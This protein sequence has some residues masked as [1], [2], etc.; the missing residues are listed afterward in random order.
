MAIKKIKATKELTVPESGSVPAF[1]QDQV[2]ADA[3]KGV[4]TNAEDN[5]VPLIYV[6][7]AQSP[8]CNRRSPDFVEGAEAGAFWLRSS[9]LPAVSGDDG[10][11]FQPCFFSKDW[12][13]WRP[14]RGGFVTR[15][16]DR[17]ADAEL[18][19]TPTPEDPDRQSWVMPNGNYVV[20]TRYHI[21]NVYLPD[22]KIMPYVIPFSSTG[23]TVSKNWMFLMNNKVIAGAKGA[24]PSFACF[25][26][27]KTKETS[28]AKGTWMKIEVTDEGWVQTAADYERGKALH[29]A[30]STGEKDIDAPDESAEQG[31]S[32][33]APDQAQ[34]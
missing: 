10:I 21:G 6:L 9:G 4:S 24:A 15:H 1:L 3:G 17:P 29:N 11:L 33:S 2:V 16:S 27:L 13:E 34:M 19:N 28:N 5:I 26:R 32:R 23:H 18:K 25:Y 8:Q 7:Q 31:S 20:E 22:G 14:N 12:V 30:F